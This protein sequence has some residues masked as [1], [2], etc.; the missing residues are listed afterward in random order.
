MKECEVCNLKI[1]LEIAK[2]T[3][4]DLSE[5]TNQ[6]VSWMLENRNM[7]LRDCLKDFRNHQNSR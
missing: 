5:E 6:F 7:D 1:F 4:L 2:E 3:I